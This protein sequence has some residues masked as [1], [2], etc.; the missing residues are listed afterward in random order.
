MKII[1]TMTVGLALAFSSMSFAAVNDSAVCRIQ[2]GQ[3]SVNYDGKTNTVTEVESVNG[4]ASDPSK[5]VSYT[6]MTQ[7]QVLKAQNISGIATAIGIDKTQ[8]VSAAIFVISQNSDAVFA[9]IKFNLTNN[10][11]KV[12]LLNG[13]TPMACQQ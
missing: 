4:K 8:I 3:I 1:F 5:G 11:T 10:V 9:M 6:L 7:G 12:A 13:W 2:G